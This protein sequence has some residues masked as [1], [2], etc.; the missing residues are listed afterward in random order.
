MNDNPLIMPVEVIRLPHYAGPEDEPALQR[1]TLGS[2]GHDLYVSSVPESFDNVTGVGMYGTGIKVHIRDCGVVGIVYIRSSYGAKM[3]ITLANAAGVIDSD[4][5][6]EIMLPLRLGIG[7]ATL[8]PGDR[9]A[10]IVFTKVELPMFQEVEQFS[11]IT[12]RGEG[13]FGSTGE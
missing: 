4:F 2:A 11:T 7:S 10:Q 12:N 13:G 5:T 3:G 6:G 8:L 9:V 1:K